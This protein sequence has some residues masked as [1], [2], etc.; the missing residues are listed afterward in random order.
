ML[1]LEIGPFAGV[2]GSIDFSGPL[3]SGR[4]PVM[5]TVFRGRVMRL[6]RLRAL[7]REALE[8]ALGPRLGGA[9]SSRS[10][11]LD[12]TVNGRDA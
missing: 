3:E 5:H 11:D 6:D 8:D 1:D 2:M 12:L 10:V 4:R 9:S 7:Q